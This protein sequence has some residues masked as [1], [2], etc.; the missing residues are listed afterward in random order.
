MYRPRLYLDTSVPSAF[1]DDRAPDRQRLT[2][3]FWREQLQAYEPVI[4]DLVLEEIS[5]TPDSQRRAEILHLVAP[6]KVLAGLETTTEDLVAEYIAR[7]VFT[8]KTAADA[9]HVAIAVTHGISYLGSWNFKH[10][11][12]VATRREV[13][14]INTLAGYQPIEIVAPPE[15]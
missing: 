6:L 11:V 4:S 8:A 5:Q 2:R 15:L 3:S 7:G 10:L 1:F 14:L 13:N 9:L 12:R